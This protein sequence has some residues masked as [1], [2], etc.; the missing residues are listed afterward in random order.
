MECVCKSTFDLS[1]VGRLVLFQSVLYRRFHC[2]I[3]IVCSSG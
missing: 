3:I 2:I 1:F